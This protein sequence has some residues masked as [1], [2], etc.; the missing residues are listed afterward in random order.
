MYKCNQR[1]TSCCRQQNMHWLSI[2]VLGLL[3]LANRTATARPADGSHAN[4]A[5]IVVVGQEG[6]SVAE[7]DDS[8]A[9]SD[10]ILPLQATLL[11]TPVTDVPPSTP[12]STPHPLSVEPTSQ[13]LPK[14][15]PSWIDMEP[16]YESEVHRFVVASIPTALKKEVDSNLEATLVEALKSYVGQQFGADADQL[17]HDRLT[18]TFIQTNLVDEK[19][20]YVAELQTGEGPLFQKWVMVEITP[21]QR[22]QLRLWVS[23]QIQRQRVLPLGIVLFGLLATV[24]L[25]HM[26]LRR[27]S[28][29]PDNLKATQIQPANP[30]QPVASQGKTCRVSRCGKFGVI[31]AL[32]VAV[33]TAVAVS[34]PEGSSSKKKRRHAKPQEEIRLESDSLPSQPT[35]PS[36]PTARQ[37]R[38]GHTVEI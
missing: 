12:P 10:A 6:S 34:S 18:A 7:I 35:V 33:L 1:E 4:L 21:E 16:D 29:L 20:S 25:T 38:Q 2:L 30:V 27:Q 19:K 22:G 8:D 28:K 9:I 32:A 36:E 26:L 17:I 5:V 13:M 3:V 37:H 15:R 14:D 23:Q 11:D 24:G 31:T